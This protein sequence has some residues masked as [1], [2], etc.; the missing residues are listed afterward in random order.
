L[1]DFKKLVIPI[2]N[3]TYMMSHEKIKDLLKKFESFISS[4]PKV[5]WKNRYKHTGIKGKAIKPNNI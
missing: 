5:K 4:I 1:S 3:P 2:I